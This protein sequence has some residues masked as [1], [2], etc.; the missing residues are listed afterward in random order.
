MASL[1]SATD[2]LTVLDLSSP[3]DGEAGEAGEAEAGGAG[4][5]LPAHLR[6]LDGASLGDSLKLT[7]ARLNK[8]KG[9]STEK[10]AEGGGDDNRARIRHPTFRDLSQS[11]EESITVTEDGARPRIDGAQGVTFDSAEVV[12]SPSIAKGLA[13]KLTNTTDSMKLHRVRRKVPHVGAAA[14]LAPP[15]SAG[16]R[17]SNEQ[18]VS[19][20]GGEGDNSGLPAHV[21]NLVSRLSNTT[22]SMQMNR[23][24]MSDP[25][26]DAA[27][28]LKPPGNKQ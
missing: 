20:S 1:S 8:K 9:N 25:S 14:A 16:S 23:R 10:Q 22:D 19:G 15:T 11:A 7:R 12:H 2:K 18:C 17:L 27:S 3:D 4:S 26:A 24:R 13:S 28:V 5:A 21:Q 6:H